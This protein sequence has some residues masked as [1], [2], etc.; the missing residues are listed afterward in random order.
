[1]ETR[2]QLFATLNSWLWGWLMIVMLIISLTSCRADKQADAWYLDMPQLQADYLKAVADAAVAEAHETCHTLPAITTPGEHPE[3]EWTIAEGRNMILVGTFTN[4]TDARRW[5][6][7]DVFRQDN[8]LPW[9]TLPHDLEAHLR[10]LP[11]CADSLECRMRI[12]Q[13]LGLPPD[14]DYD[15]MVFFYVAPEG[16]FRPSPDPEI[17]DHS[18]SP[19][20][21]P[22]SSTP[23]CKGSA[24]EDCKSS[25]PAH[26]RKWFDANIA[27]SY[28]SDTPYPWT[29][30]GYTYDWH[31]GTESVRGPGEFI[32]HPG[33]WVRLKRKVTVW[34]WY[35]ETIRDAGDK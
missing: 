17:D 12:V 21:A 35:R 34:R 10:R 22:D 2:N 27:F 24:S 32:V 5:T 29:R 30:L 1:M 25:V 23:D 33:A 15:R 31:R 4:P 7:G 26:Y 20:F 18:A 13:L 6:A 8:L 19:D 28:H 9:V 16:L 11:P 14:C 3:Q